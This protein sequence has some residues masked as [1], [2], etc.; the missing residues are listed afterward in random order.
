LRRI[1]FGART[2][3]ASI[4]RF[5]GV[6]PLADKMRRYSPYNYSFNNPLRFIDPDGRDA[7]DWIKLKDGSIKFDGNVNNQAQATAKYGSEATDIGKSGVYTNGQGQQVNLNADGTATSSTML[8]EVSVT[9]NAES[10]VMGTVDAVNDAFGLS[11]DLNTSV[12][13]GASKLGN[14]LDAASP[15]INALDNV[16][17]Y[18]GIGGASISV[19][20]FGKDLANGNFSV[21]KLAKASVD[22]GLVMLKVNPVT[23]AIIGVADGLLT[24]TG[25][26]D[27]IFKGIDNGIDQYKSSQTIK[28]QRVDTS[29]IKIR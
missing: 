23:G 29:K 7:T 5:D 9:A 10:G 27:A 6:D 13:A 8:N 25:A 16:A 3:N 4:G 24:V 1:S 19:L 15:V 21:G 18:S 14:A 17:K 28:S 20:D 2:Y 11:N 26:K 22:V 12:V